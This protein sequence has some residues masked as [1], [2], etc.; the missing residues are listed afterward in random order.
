MP[1]SLGPPSR[2]ESEIDIIHVLPIGREAIQDILKYEYKIDGFLYRRAAGDKIALTMGWF[3]NQSVFLAF[4]PGI[5]A[6][7]AAAVA[8]NIGSSHYSFETIKVGLVV[9]SC[10]GMQL[11]VMEW[12]SF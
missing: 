1:P 2:A 4:K 12:R 7:S 9:G 5:G 10:G 11:I 6:V 3:R 8:A